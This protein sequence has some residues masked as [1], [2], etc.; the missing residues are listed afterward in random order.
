MG[1]M[2]GMMGG[3]FMMLLWIIFWVAVIVLV[4]WA[5][6]RLFRGRTGDGRTRGTQ[7]RVDPAEE[8]LRQR[9]ARGEID[10]GEYERSLQTLRG[11]G[12]TDENGGR[13]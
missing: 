8:T 5:V 12:S 2:D 10:A 11:D 4:A 13:R 6:V 3:G 1:G 7:D 9:Y